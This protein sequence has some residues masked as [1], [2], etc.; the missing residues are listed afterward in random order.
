MAKNSLM[1]NVHGFSSYQLVFARNP[2]LSFGGSTSSLRRNNYKSSDRRTHIAAFHQSRKA[3]MESECS[4]R[5][6]RALR[7]QTRPASEKY[8]MDDKIFYERPDNTEWKGPATVIGQDG[9]VVI[10]RHGGVIVRVDTCRMRKVV[11]DS[12]IQINNEK[13]ETAADPRE[14][15]ETDT[16]GSK[17]QIDVQ[18]EETDEVEVTRMLITPTIDHHIRNEDWQQL[19]LCETSFLLMNRSY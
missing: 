19:D 13:E 14:K 10:A 11:E 7:K 6:R 17:V 3:F 12:T 18:G 16:N 5:I 9:V 2:N 8:I 1:S 15:E 4:E